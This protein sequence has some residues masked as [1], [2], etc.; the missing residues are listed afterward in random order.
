MESNNK[1]IEIL[2]QQLQKSL[3][4]FLLPAAEEQTLLTPSLPLLCLGTTAATASGHY[5]A[6][7][8]PS[9]HPLYLLLLSQSPFSAVRPTSGSSG[10]LVLGGKIP[11]PA[12]PQQLLLPM[13]PSSTMATPAPGD[14]CRGSLADL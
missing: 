12:W 3:Q 7:V 8:L 2:L 1:H 10:T 11:F 5:R 9:H 14:Q 13:A 6:N 4:L